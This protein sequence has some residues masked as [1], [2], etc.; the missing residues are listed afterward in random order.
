MKYLISGAGGQLG[1]EWVRLLDE[2]TGGNEFAALKHSDFDITDRESVKKTLKKEKPDVLI[3]CA[4][5]TDV[6]GAENDR[7]KANLINHIAV[8]N[9]AAE[10]ANA[11]IKL[12]HYSTDYVF[13]GDQE[14]E[15]IYP[16]GYP[17]DAETGPVNI[18]GKTKLAGE[19]ALK[20]E[21]NDYL[22]IRVSWLCGSDGKNFVKTMLRLGS[23]RNEVSVV[24]DQIGSPAF[25]FDVAEK[26][27][28]LVQKDKTGTYHISS[29]GKITWADFAKEIFSQAGMNVVVNRVTSEEFKTVA[30]RPAFSLLSKRKIVDEELTPVPWKSG[31]SELLNRLK[32]K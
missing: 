11:G 10:C 7:E 14:D 3:N 18:Y 21:T 31:L 28:K 23:D 22:L 6:D 19:R 30:K 16:D 1:R 20:R 32:R 17:E 27:R 29:E 26:T 25:T 15:Q 24:D 9:L 8:K 2:S 4:A 12:V 5:Y 13:P